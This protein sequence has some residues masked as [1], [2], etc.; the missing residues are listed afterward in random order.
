MKANHHMEEGNIRIKLSNIVES[1]MQAKLRMNFSWL[2]MERFKHSDLNV[3][4][5]DEANLKSR[6]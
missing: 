4:K 6:G 2:L 3:P 5:V 1:L